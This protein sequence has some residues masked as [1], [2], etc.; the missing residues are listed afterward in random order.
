MHPASL[1]SCCP[2]AGVGSPLLTSQDLADL[3]D[4]VNASGITP[5]SVHQLTAA[6]SAGPVPGVLLLPLLLLL[7][8]LDAR[9][10][11]A[12]HFPCLRT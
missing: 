4:P 7:L 10:L 3:F 8:L 11:I 12:G 9:L 1:L 5:S 6:L 2:S